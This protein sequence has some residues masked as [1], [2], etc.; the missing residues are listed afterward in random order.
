MNLETMKAKLLVIKS[1]V[2]EWVLEGIITADVAESVALM[3]LDYVIK[4]ESI[5]VSVE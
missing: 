5:E 2:S 1:E 4:K 3:I